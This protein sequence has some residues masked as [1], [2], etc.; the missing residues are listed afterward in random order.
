MLDDT[1]TQ[2][3]WKLTRI[4]KTLK[5]LHGFTKNTLVFDI[6]YWISHV[7]GIINKN[8]QQLYGWIYLFIMKTSG[9]LPSIQIAQRF[10]W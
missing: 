6:I 4:Q 1:A 8:S 7:F 9:K 10:M 2:G 3:L 5:E